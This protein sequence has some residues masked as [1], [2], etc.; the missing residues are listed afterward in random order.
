METGRV[1]WYNELKGFGYGIATIC[2]PGSDVDNV[3]AAHAMM[4][5]TQRKQ[6]SSD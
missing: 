1:L 2:L 4:E 5:T 6:T 3:P